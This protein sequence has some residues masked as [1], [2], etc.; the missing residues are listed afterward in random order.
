MTT[1]ANDDPIWMPL[2]GTHLIEASAGTGKTFT[3]EMLVLR[4]VLEK[5]LGIGRIL[6]MTFTRAATA[7]LKNR[8]YD[9][10]AK[11]QRALSARQLPEDSEV[12]K[13]ILAPHLEDEEALESV[14]RALAEFS[15]AQVLT[16]HGFCQRVLSDHAFAGGIDAAMTVDSTE[17]I[18][19]E[20]VRLCF[21]R[22]IP[23]DGP[24]MRSLIEHQLAPQAKF[25]DAMANLA[26]HEG[27]ALLDGASAVFA[28]DKEGRALENITGA[29]EV[30]RREY[31]KLHEEICARKRQTDY[32][33]ITQR[34]ARLLSEEGRGLAGRI[35]QD[36]D[37]VLIDEFQDTDAEQYGIFK[38]LFL[39]HARSGDYLCFVGDPKQ[40]IYRFRNADVK[41]YAQAKKALPEE[42]RW[43]IVKNFR[44]CREL[45][46]VINA[47]FSSK[48]F[49][50]DEDIAY[51]GVSCGNPDKRPLC[52][53]GSPV[54]SLDVLML[55]DKLVDGY[56]L[57][58]C[59]HLASRIA[60]MLDPA[61]CFTLEGRPVT[62]DDIVVLVR[63]NEE[64]DKVRE[65]LRPY[66]IAV[67]AST[68]KSVFKSEEFAE[69]KAVLLGVV[70]AN[71][72]SYVKTALATA[73]FR[74]VVP[75]GGL[76]ESALEEQMTVF[77]G[78]RD[79]CKE[80]GAGYLI[81]KL[82]K[83]NGVYPMLLSS[84]RGAA[85][86]TNWEHLVEI[87]YELDAVWKIPEAL[88]SHLLA[89]GA[90]EASEDDAGE[91]PASLRMP[92]AK[93]VVTAMTYHTSKGLQ[94]PIVFLPF[95]GTFFKPHLKQG[96]ALLSYY[97][98]EGR[99]HY[100]ADNHAGKKAN[101]LSGRE[102][103]SDRAR[104]AYVAVT[105][106]ASHVEITDSTCAAHEGFD[107]RLRG[108]AGEPGDYWKGLQDALPGQVRVLTP[109]DIA[110][111]KP[112]R[113]LRPEAGTL[114]ARPDAEG[115]R[116]S[117]AVTSYSSLARRKD[118]DAS[119][120]QDDL[121]RG[122]TETRDVQASHA[123]LK[124]ECG[125]DAGDILFFPRGAQPGEALHAFLEAIDFTDE[126]SWKDAALEVAGR[127]FARDK[128]ASCA[129]TMVSMARDVLSVPLFGDVRLKDVSASHRECEMPFYMNVADTGAAQALSSLLRR[130]ARP[131]Y[132][133]APLAPGVS[134]AGYL[135][136]F[137]DLVVEVDGR[138]FILDWK[139]NCLNAKAPFAD[140]Q[141]FFKDAFGQAC[142]QACI[143]EHAYSLQYLIYSVALVRYLKVR[144]GQTFDFERHF[145]GVR[146]VFVRGAR[147][148]LPGVGVWED[149]PERALLE[150]IDAILG[151]AR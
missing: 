75:M 100:V 65:A 25:W 41:V 16:I 23:E 139:S 46:S 48:D 130:S 63:K 129:E 124:A 11:A 72:A 62:A 136:G 86:L 19:K 2:A 148:G 78:L 132:G 22:C 147:P 3:V 30:F 116:E 122:A 105:R 91:S 24:L 17:S 85:S 88:L 125:M 36:Y 126:R 131:G 137:I 149:R 144:L 49:F 146:Y 114:A 31:P 5:R 118:E 60:Q 32:A 115:R 34:L 43:N 134:L 12:F 66:D 113:V 80:K 73:L 104:L 53:Q 94:F 110:L 95:F 8:L 59:A 138:F 70:Y 69:L 89:L 145:G 58:A 52:R 98:E 133:I 68:R 54:E 103:A 93:N 79:L 84:D 40:S 33:G 140:A 6:V 56:G 83:E 108:G 37:A 45:L 96:R 117:W 10:L 14:R 27:Q 90:S 61:E 15:E 82:L 109:D 99:K 35:A 120:H 92:R 67:H 112:V 47:V 107:T 81:A 7:E 77:A 39:E 57:H 135:K 128:L 26:M 4:L 106:A 64:I 141:A 127:F 13:A 151:G 76:S 123:R 121:P 50:V 21:S 87:L 74:A 38:T 42:C 111:G 20:A 9:R 28:P 102:E 51:G 142:M 119:E 71:E 101:A 29:L 44:S 97:D 143:E 1:R 150:E 18:H 55:E